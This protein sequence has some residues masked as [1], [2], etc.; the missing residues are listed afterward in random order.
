[1]H[2]RDAGRYG[3][4]IRLAIVTCVETKYSRRR[5]QRGLGR[6]A[7]TRVVYE[8]GPIWM[9]GVSAR[10]RCGGSRRECPASHAHRNTSRPVRAAASCTATASCTT[11]NTSASGRGESAMRTFG[12]ATATGCHHAPSAVIVGSGSNESIDTWIPVSAKPSCATGRISRSSGTM[13]SRRACDAGPREF[14][15]R[16]WRRRQDRRGGAAVRV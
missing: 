11:P 12:S 7:S 2:R 10:G 4:E 5:R 1:M 9:T 16:V 14:W 6:V 13:P 8:P 15:S 3:D